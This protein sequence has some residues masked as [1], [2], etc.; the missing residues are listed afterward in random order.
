MRRRIRRGVML[1]MIVLECED[2]EGKGKGNGMLVVMSGRHG[3][4]NGGI[5]RGLTWGG[6]VGRVSGWRMRTMWSSVLDDDH[7]DDDDD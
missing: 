3:E 6:K 2:E 4:D 5:R 7:H 1:S